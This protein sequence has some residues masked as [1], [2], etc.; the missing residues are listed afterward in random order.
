MH[1]NQS[2]GKFS[3]N[4]FLVHDNNLINAPISLRFDVKLNKWE[5]LCDM[6]IGRVF[7]NCA[8][9]NDRLYAIGGYLLRRSRPFKWTNSVEYFTAAENR[10]TSVAPMNS[11]TGITLT[12]VVNGYIYVMCGDSLE[13]YDPVSNMWLRVSEFL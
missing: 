11:G 2:K 6:S 10:W 1:Q 8:V 9:L 3:F 4:S 13:K 5:S 7:A 12:G